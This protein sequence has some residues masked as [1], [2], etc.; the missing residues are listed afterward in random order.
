[1]A[2]AVAM[3]LAAGFGTRLSPLTEELPKPLVPV[4][5][6]SVLA[7][8][9]AA[10]ARAGIERVVVNAHHHAAMIA[11]EATRLGAAISEEAEILGTAGG[12]AHA[13]EALGSGPLLV[14]NGDIIADFDVGALLGGYCATRPFALLAIEGGLPP[15]EGNV[16]LDGARVVRLRDRAFAPESS[17][18]RFV[19]V[20]VLSAQARG[21]LPAVGCLVGDLHLPALARGERI[22]AAPLVTRFDDIG[23]ADAYLAANLHW[24][25]AR[26]F[27]L[28][29]GVELAPAIELHETIVGAGAR[30]EGRGV[31]ARSVIWPGA[32]AR[33]PLSDAIVTPQRI[34][35]LREATGTTSPR[36]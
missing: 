8:V 6:R 17:G 4:G 16:G 28:A 27:H 32:T 20:Q 19:G 34:V 11:D 12:V 26:P 7:H 21:A 5:D 23:T 9:I 24:L 36:C 22:E 14:H 29:S 31:I 1:M 10:I 13:R 2:V 33:A 35:R 3:V 25:A 30:L 18:G 15:G